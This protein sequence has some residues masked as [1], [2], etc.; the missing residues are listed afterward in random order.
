MTEQLEAKSPKDSAGETR[1]MVMPSQANP[2]GTA[3]GG[4]IVAW[5]DIIAAMAAQRH[6]GTEAVTVGI[7]SIVFKKPIRIG[8]SVLLTAN[9][10]GCVAA[11]ISFGLVD[12]NQDRPMGDSLVYTDIMKEH[13][14]NAGSEKSTRSNI[15]VSLVI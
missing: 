5:M 14:K 9:T 11:A 7:D 10:I 8:D 12:K 15:F 3:F 2:H 1:Y 6:S 4:A 13:P